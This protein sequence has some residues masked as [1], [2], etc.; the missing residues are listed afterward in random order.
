MNTNKNHFSK[1]D[2]ESYYNISKRKNL[3]TA[4][5]EAKINF[6]KH[7]NECPKCNSEYFLL[8]SAYFNENEKYRRRSK[9]RTVSLVTAS[10][11]V[12]LFLIINPMKEK[13]NSTLA[14]NKKTDS[15]ETGQTSEQTDTIENRKK[16]ETAA[17]NGQ[18]N[19]GKLRD[20]Y[21]V[22][23][24]LSINDNSTD[25]YA[26]ASVNN[27]EL[28]KSFKDD[29]IQETQI[30][31]LNIRTTSEIKLLQPKNY[32]ALTPPI[33]FQWEKTSDEITIVLKNNN[34]KKVFEKSSS[35]SSTIIF[36]EKLEPGVYYWDLRINNRVK[37]KRKF[38]IL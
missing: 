19:K 22:Y 16:Y 30:K 7:L 32:I 36:N 1:T 9:I 6:E 3:S 20:L 17:D 18:E 33:T 25:F 23:S 5:M 31:E 11:I 27:V 35:D 21:K 26:F 29:N 12:L 15:K 14:E 24:E 2:F 10:S 38:Y 28:P 13:V 34:N 8:K 4:E 37:I